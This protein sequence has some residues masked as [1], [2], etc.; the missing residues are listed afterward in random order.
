MSSAKPLDE[1]R[2]RLGNGPA[3]GAF[4]ALAEEHRRAGRLDEAVA[5]CREGLARYPTYVSARVTLGRA[6]LDSGDVPAAI[7]ELEQAV[8]QA[9]D[10]LAAVRALETARATGDSA[11]APES[12]SAQTSSAET[13]APSAMAWLT[14]EVVAEEP[15][16]EET[17]ALEPVVE[18]PVAPPPPVVSLQGPSEWDETIYAPLVPMDMPEPAVTAA[19]EPLVTPQEAQ[20]ADAVADTDELPV[21]GYDWPASTPPSWLTTFPSEA[22]AGTSDAAALLGDEVIAFPAFHA[23][24]ESESESESEP[25]SEPE[26]ESELEPVAEAEAEV[27][28]ESPAVELADSPSALAPGDLPILDVEAALAPTGDEEVSSATDADF[29]AAFPTEAD[30]PAVHAATA[31]LPDVRHARPDPPDALP[32]ALDPLP[33]AD[34]DPLSVWAGFAEAPARSDAA[35]E[36]GGSVAAVMDEVFE[37]AATP[38]AAAVAT[39]QPPPTLGATADVPASAVATPAHGTL[40]TLESLLLAIRARRAALAHVRA[41]VD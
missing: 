2:R 10:N 28:F 16:A 27:E 22:P 25:E 26:S 41:G 24:P 21:P 34:V 33:A 1:L 8:A 35:R 32:D 15:V 40:Q 4:A 17:V 30:A 12:S 9:P 31:E 13:P 36:W 7:A 29:A 23:E 20:A 37:S 38:F 5:V 18:E 11:G 14:G 19:P 39:P 3:P 6:L